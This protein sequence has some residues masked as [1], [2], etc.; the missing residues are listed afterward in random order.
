MTLMLNQ[1]FFFSGLNNAEILGILQTSTTRM[2]LS[3]KRFPFPPGYSS[4]GDS[5]VNSTVTACP[6]RMSEWAKCQCG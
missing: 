4:Y 3:F 2:S 6:S 1:L 5:T